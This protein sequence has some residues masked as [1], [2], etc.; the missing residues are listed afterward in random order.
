M[1]IGIMIGRGGLPSDRESQLKFSAAWYYVQ[2]TGTYNENT[3][4]A[5]FLC[6]GI[7]HAPEN[8]LAR[9]MDLIEHTYLHPPGQ[10]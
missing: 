8:R 4:H 1:M 6:H 9:G 7:Q 5:I 10:V 2:A 3:L